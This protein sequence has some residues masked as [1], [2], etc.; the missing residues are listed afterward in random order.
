MNVVF[1]YEGEIKRVK[2]FNLIKL[3][4][5][6]MTYLEKTLYFTAIFGVLVIMMLFMKIF[7]LYFKLSRIFKIIL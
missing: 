6:E 4:D 5:E 1:H 3:N 7:P 2:G